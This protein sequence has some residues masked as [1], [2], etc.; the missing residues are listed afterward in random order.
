MSKSVAEAW[1]SHS[2]RQGLTKV[3]GDVSQGWQGNAGLVLAR[4]EAERGVRAGTPERAGRGALP[5]LDWPERW[6][7]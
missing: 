4:G 1:A 3:K 2:Q 7:G 6:A 5:G